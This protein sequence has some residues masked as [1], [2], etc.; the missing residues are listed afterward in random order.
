VRVHAVA[1]EVPE[2]AHCF[3]SSTAIYES[4]WTLPESYFAEG[5]RT[6]AADG[7]SRGDFSRGL[8]ATRLV[9]EAL[10]DKDDIVKAR[11]IQNVVLS[12]DSQ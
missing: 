10:A 3:K 11:G 4:T 8:L 7:F 1:L 6:S 5:S 9:Q 12:P 2:T